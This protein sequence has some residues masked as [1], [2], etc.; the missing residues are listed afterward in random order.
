MAALCQTVSTMARSSLDSRARSSRSV[1]RA[2]SNASLLSSICREASA[3]ASPSALYC[4]SKR[5]PRSDTSRPIRAW[6]SASLEQR[7]RRSASRS[8]AKPSTP[9]VGGG[10]NSWTWPAPDRLG[11]VQPTDWPACVGVRSASCRF[12]TF[13]LSCSSAAR[14]SAASPILDSRS[15]RRESSVS[16]RRV[17]TCSPPALV[18]AACCA[19][20]SFLL[21]RAS[22]ASASD[23]AERWASSSCLTCLRLACQPLSRLAAV[24][25]DDWG[26]AALSAAGPTTGPPSGM[27]W[28]GRPAGCEAAAGCAGVTGWPSTRCVGRFHGG[29]PSERRCG[30]WSSRPRAETGDC[31][32]GV[33]NAPAPRSRWPSESWRAFCAGRRSPAEGRLSG[34]S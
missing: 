12:R 15:C 28:P 1:S 4:S 22:S 9:C 3:I 26:T 14:S 16:K 13:A 33:F 21:T 23:C 20:S 5:R 18:W 25:T 11:E 10:H 32:R 2:F 31:G 19:S 24:S 6:M 29:S 7:L 27:P 17:A 34:D 8:R 30:R